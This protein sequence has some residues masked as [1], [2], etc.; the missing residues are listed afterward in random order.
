MSCGNGFEISH[1]EHFCSNCTGFQSGL[2]VDCSK[3][4]ILKS[5]CKF[6]QGRILM[7]SKPT[8]EPESTWKRY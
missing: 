5:G 1:K 4:C 2:Y 8:K 7:T 3:D 6:Q